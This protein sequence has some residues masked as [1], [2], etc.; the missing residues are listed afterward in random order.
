MDILYYIV[1]VFCFFYIL[2]LPFIIEEYSIMGNIYL[3]IKASTQFTAYTLLILYSI[4]C[5]IKLIIYFISI[6]VLNKKEFNDYKITY[7][8]KIVNVL[9]YIVLITITYWLSIS[10]FIASINEISWFSLLVYVVCDVIVLISAGLFIPYMIV[11]YFPK[12]RS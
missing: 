3:P 12:E 4:K 10:L 6:L 9:I 8:Q 2:G 1:A 7:F 11:K 5:Y